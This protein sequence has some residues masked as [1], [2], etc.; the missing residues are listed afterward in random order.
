M[1]VLAFVVTLAAGI[2]SA[3]PWTLRSFFYPKPAGLPPVV[4]K[5]MEELLPRLQAALEKRA[6]EVVKLLQPGLTTEEIAGLEGRGGFKL[7]PDLRA[8]YRW[9][10]GMLAHGNAGLLPGRRFLPLGEVV[11][12][13]TLIAGQVA[14]QDWYHRL[15]FSIFAGHRRSW[16][17]IIDDGSGDGYFY[18]PERTEAAG[19]FFYNM[20]ETRDYL[21]F[22]SLRNFLA[23]AT[24]C[25]E[26]GAIKPAKSGGELEEDYVRTRKILERFGL[27]REPTP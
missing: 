17:T 23:G 2:L 15:M 1:R 20:S 13:R 6:P 25:Y 10:N 26:T 8:L 12:E 27:S 19:A 11:R 18:D 21:W 16:V 9:R 22:P 3:A 7:S 24:E 14:A 5:S 4:A